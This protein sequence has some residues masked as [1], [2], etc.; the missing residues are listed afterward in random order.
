[1]KHKKIPTFALHCLLPGSQN[2]TAAH[3][4]RPLRHT[5]TGQQQEKLGCHLKTRRMDKTLKRIAKLFREMVKNY[6]D[7]GNLWKNIAA[8]KEA[9][10]LMQTL[11]DIVPEEFNTPEEKADLLNNMLEQMEETLTPRFCIEVREYIETLAPD[12]EHNLRTLQKLRDFINPDL[13]MEEYC[14][15]Y[16]RSLKFDPV[17]RTPEWEAVIAEVEAE[18]AKKLRWHRRGMGFCFAYW[19][20][21]E[22]SLARRGIR[23][24]SPSAMNPRVMFD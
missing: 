12:N 22:T 16:R 3:P 17:E 19:H 13:P 21:K 5:R 14:R 4:L 24:N 15:K 11:P 20:Q 2:E 10:N 18:C 9:F 7:D 8:G 1:M 6:E 23:W